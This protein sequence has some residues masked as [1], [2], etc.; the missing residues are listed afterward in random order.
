MSVFGSMSDAASGPTQDGRGS[1]ASGP[2]LS[3]LEKAEFVGVSRV[4]YSGAIKNAVMA[5]RDAGHDIVNIEVA[6]P[7]MISVID[8][9]EV[10]FSAIV[11]IVYRI[12]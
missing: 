12:G 8:D 6:P 11:G 9:G 3:K 1:D 2:A 4:S 10:E 5:A 7:W